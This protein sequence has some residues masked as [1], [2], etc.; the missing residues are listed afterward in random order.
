[1]EI[2]NPQIF[3]ADRSIVYLKGILEYVLIK[4][5]EFYVPCDIVILEMEEDSQISI[6]LGWPFLASIGAIIDV[7]R[8]KITLEVGEKKV[9]F[10][11]FKMAQQSPIMT[12]YFWVDVVEVCAKDGLPQVPKEPLRKLR[13][14]RGI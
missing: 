8:G 3:Q 14:K 13:R 11:V 5:G 9:E 10:D 2:P 1:M 7:K 4:V 12:S 6:I